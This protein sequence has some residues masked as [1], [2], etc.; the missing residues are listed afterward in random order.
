MTNAY[1]RAFAARGN[2]GD[3]LYG[4]GREVEIVVRVDIPMCWV[5]G[6]G[7]FA[8]WGGVPRCAGCVIYDQ[9]FAASLGHPRECFN[10]CYNEGGGIVINAGRER[11]Y[12]GVLGML[13][14]FA[15]RGC[16]RG[17]FW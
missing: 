1:K 11:G 9:V 7:V 12:P 15:T 6:W 2:R 8:T 13:S 4:C 5:C 17:C 16:P 3:T 14:P 10:G